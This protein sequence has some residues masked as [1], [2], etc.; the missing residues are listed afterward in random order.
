MKPGDTLPVSWLLRRHSETGASVVTGSIPGE[1]VNT[2]PG[3]DG[4]TS[5]TQCRH[6]RQITWFGQ[7][8]LF[9]VAGVFSLAVALI[10]VQGLGV[11][12]C[13]GGVWAVGLETCPDISRCAGGGFDSD[14]NRR[15]GGD[16]GD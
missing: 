1:A 13:A 16:G 6:M 8:T 12:V 7:R 2:G 4:S 9:G 11:Q 15:L 3:C 10:G 14:A 5:G